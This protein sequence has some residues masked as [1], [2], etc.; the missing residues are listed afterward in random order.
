[1]QTLAIGD[2][3]T[4]GE[5]RERLARLGAALLAATL[6]EIVAGR[7]APQPQDPALATHATKLHPAGA[8]IDW[9]EPASVLARQIRAYAPKP[10]AWTTWQ[11]ERLKLHRATPLAGRAA[12]PGQVWRAGPEG[13]DVA[14]GEG[15]VRVLE[16][17]APGGRVMNARDFLNGRAMLG[18]RL[19]L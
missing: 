1:M 9:R 16:M 3:E 7:I 5:L 13:M 11:G 17:Q 18:E 8:E 4:A 19:G 12:E 14:A 2:L 15:S 6:P 10:G